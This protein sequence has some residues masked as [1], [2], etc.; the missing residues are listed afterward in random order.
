M[1]GTIASDGTGRYTQVLELPKDVDISQVAVGVESPQAAPRPRKDD[2]D[3]CAFTR[4]F[5][6]LFHCDD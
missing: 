5:K 2:D 4:F 1:I 3:D 6:K